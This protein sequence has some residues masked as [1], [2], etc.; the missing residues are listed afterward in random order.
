MFYNILRR[1]IILRGDT[2]L[3]KTHKMILDQ[4][5][6]R[7]PSTTFERWYGTPQLAPYV[8]YL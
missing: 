8:E 1:Y 2:R 6:R 7:Q 5:T 3:Q 4:Y